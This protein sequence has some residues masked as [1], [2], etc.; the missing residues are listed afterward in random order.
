[1]RLLSIAILATT[2]CFA[3]C[4]PIVYPYEA[5]GA[6]TVQLAPD[7]QADVVWVQRIDPKEKR[8]QLFRCHNSPT[9][10]LCIEAKTP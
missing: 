7:Q 1:M 5:L 9:G 8:V 2:A 6:H 10:P 3:G 4:A